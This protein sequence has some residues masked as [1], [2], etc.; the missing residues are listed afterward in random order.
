M[1]S[2]MELF[3]M[4]I[5]VCVLNITPFTQSKNYPDRDLDRCLNG[6]ILS[7]V[8]TEPGCDLDNFNLDIRRL[9]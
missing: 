3:I 7:R 6:E 5:Q 9:R 4:K 8:N 1:R 2:K